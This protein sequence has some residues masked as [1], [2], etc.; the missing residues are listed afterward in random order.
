[1]FWN[2]HTG[3]NLS[4]IHTGSQVHAVTMRIQYCAIVHTSCGTWHASPVHPHHQLPRHGPWLVCQSCTSTS[5]LQGMLFHPSSH[6]AVLI[7]TSLQAP[8]QILMHA[9]CQSPQV[10]A[11]QWSRHEREIL[12][13]HGYSKN[14]LCLW[15]YPSLVK[16]RVHMGVCARASV[17]ECA[18]AQL[19]HH[20]HTYTHTHTQ[21]A[22]LTGH[23][24][25]VL[26]MATSPDGS[27][28]VS[29]GADETLRL[30]RVFGEPA[31][32]KDE[33]GAAGLGGGLLGGGAP[34]GGL[35]S[36]R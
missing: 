36:I 2:A 30:W 11:L 5:I 29:A 16:V 1:M 15:K 3:M 27:S 28:V 26:H 22:E 10:C 33:K 17:R 34:L 12:S 19:C 7:L 13:S 24:G 14:Q 31:L 4:S 8:A 35:R 21:V 23:Q 25:R 20:T 9:P 18:S 32:A 6:G